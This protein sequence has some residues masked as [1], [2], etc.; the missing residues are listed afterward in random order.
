MNVHDKFKFPLSS[1]QDADDK[2]SCWRFPKD[3]DWQIPGPRLSGMLDEK[4]KTSS[5]MN[6]YS[7]AGQL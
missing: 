3:G 2:V 4:N 7:L 5:Q 6:N 1:K